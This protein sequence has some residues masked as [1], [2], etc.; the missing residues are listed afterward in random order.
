MAATILSFPKTKPAPEAA[1]IC[2]SNPAP[3]ASS[4]RGLQL[5]EA[6]TIATRVLRDTQAQA[7]RIVAQVEREIAQQAAR[8][9]Q[10]K[11]NPQPAPVAVMPEPPTNVAFKLLFALFSFARPA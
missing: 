8:H 6:G 1:T 5:V 7:I 4:F 2:A 3:A 11:L 10:A 9:R